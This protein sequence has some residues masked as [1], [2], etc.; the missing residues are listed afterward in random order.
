MGDKSA[1]VEKQTREN[2]GSLW[3]VFFIFSLISLSAH[4]GSVGYDL[5]SRIKVIFKK[6]NSCIFIIKQFKFEAHAKLS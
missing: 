4:E 3:P 6:I 1:P 2:T 5:E